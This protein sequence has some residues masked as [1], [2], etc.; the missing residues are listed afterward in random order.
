M[1]RD[2]LQTSAI[3][4]NSAY[5]DKLILKNPPHR[6]QKTAATSQCKQCE[7]EIDELVWSRRQKKMI[8]RTLCTS[9][10]RKNNPRQPKEASVGGKSDEVSA[11]LLGS[12]ETVESVPKSST[13]QE[14]H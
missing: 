12:I 13:F 8:E 14:M 3:A 9:C 2:A 10:W 1:A 6:A 7:V 4:A 5:K 11:L